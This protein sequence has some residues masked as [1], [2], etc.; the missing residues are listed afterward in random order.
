MEKG[1]IWRFCKRG[2]ESGSGLPLSVKKK[3][4]LGIGVAEKREDLRL[5]RV[6]L[7]L[8]LSKFRTRVGIPRSGDR[9]KIWKFRDVEFIVS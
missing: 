4:P 5:R 6:K 7:G 9:R 8:G 3:D 2:V 1:V